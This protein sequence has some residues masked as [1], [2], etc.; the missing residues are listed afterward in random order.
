MKKIT[1]RDFLK[2]STAAAFAGAFLPAIIPATALGKGGAIAPSERIVFGC[3]GMGGQMRGHRDF[4]A[5]YRESQVIAV[6]DVRKSN[7]EDSKRAVEAIS[8]RR[9]EL[10]NYKGCDTTEDYQDIIGRDDIDAVVI[11]TPDHWHVQIALAAA[12]AGKHVYLEKPMSLTIEEGKILSD[13]VRRTGIKLQVGTQQRTEDSF[14]K[15]A[16]IVRNKLIG[17]VKEIYTDIGVFAQPKILKEEP[18]PEGFNYEKWLGPSPWYPY[19]AER[20]RSFWNGGW[21]CFWDYGCRKDGDWG[22]HHYDIIQWALG[23]DDSFPTRFCPPNTDGSKCRFFEYENGPRVY[24]NPFGQ[25]GGTKGAMIRFVGT[26]GEVRASRGNYIY[27]D[28]E[29]LAKG[30]LPNGCT[31]LQ[32]VAS[33]REDLIACIRNGG[34]PI[35]NADVGYHT[36]TTCQLSA[37]ALR[38]N[39]VVNW[40]AKNEKVIGDP[41]AQS[42]TSRVRRA[43]YFLGV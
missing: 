7:R 1:R 32:R 14:R 27:T 41:V 2:K 13:A 24:V 16:E 34:T 20:V 22:A 43:P 12:K 18:I 17:D 5:G 29:W 40:D 28:P 10:Q 37:M 38:L 35:C 42:M 39:R 3:I 9:S 26:K 8:A 31:R 15:A 4:Y 30:A 36:S 6:C 11:A 33:I 21:R 19:N 23:K 25:N